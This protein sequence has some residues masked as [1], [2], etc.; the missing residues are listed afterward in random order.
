MLS[1]Q[2]ELQTDSPVSKSVSELT[3]SSSPQEESTAEPVNSLYRDHLTGIGNRRHFEA[4]LQEALSS[5]TS[6]P[7][8]LL[9]D[10]DRFKA[11]NDT[12]GHAVGDILLRLV[13]ERFA[14]LLA[15]SDTLARLGGDEFGVITHAP[16]NVGGLAARIVNVIQRP[17][18]IEG[19]P[20]NIGVSIGI[21]QAPQDGLDGGQLLKNA[22]LALYQ[23]K[24]TGRSCFLYFLPEME[25]RAQ[26][27]REL[28]LALRKAV[29]LRQLELHYRPQVDIETKR[30]AGTRE[31]IQAV[32]RLWKPRGSSVRPTQ[33]LR[34]CKVEITT[35]KGVKYDVSTP[36]PFP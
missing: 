1:T 33:Q 4:R 28:E 36:I 14:Q 15:P 21:A 32:V 27:K 23:A 30:L 25:V 17:Y 19:S 5:R 18:L 2:Q 16:A 12:L 7:T 3:E 22:D 31:P 24:A 26:E 20:V 13:S 9:L 34:R 6:Q 11:V 8:L 29:P 35:S 10:L